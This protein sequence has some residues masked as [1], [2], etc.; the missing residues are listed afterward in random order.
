MSYRVIVLPAVESQIL[1][2]ALFI[3]ED[4]IDRAIDWEQALREHI[5]SLGDLPKACPISEPESRAFG[6]DIRKT[7]FGDYL[8]FY[9]VDDEHQSVYLLTFM[10][11]AQRKDC[12]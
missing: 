11:G 3:A 1:D 12:D 9:R 7:N 6:R 10:H 8:L 4:S 2:Q 5:L